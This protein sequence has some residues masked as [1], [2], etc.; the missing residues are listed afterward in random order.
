MK[1]SDQ[2]S[3]G[4]QAKWAMGALGLVLAYFGAFGVLMYPVIQASTHVA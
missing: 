3:L 1:K 4:K 2:A